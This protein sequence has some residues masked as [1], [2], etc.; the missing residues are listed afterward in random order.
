MLPTKTTICT[1]KKCKHAEIK[2]DKQKKLAGILTTKNLKSKNMG[3]WR[4]DWSDTFWY[5]LIH[6]MWMTRVS[7]MK[8]DESGAIWGHWSQDFETRLEPGSGP[9]LSGVPRL[10]ADLNLCHRGSLK[11][12]QKLQK[13]GV[14]GVGSVSLVWVDGHPK[15]GGGDHPFWLNIQLCQQ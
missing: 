3:N 1:I 2:T 13:W 10:S 12:V 11:W 8:C 4:P 9:G 6:D 7:V 5:I 15:I 14:D